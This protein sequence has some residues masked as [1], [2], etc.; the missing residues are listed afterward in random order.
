LVGRDL[1]ESSIFVPYS[2][3]IAKDNKF[4]IGNRIHSFSYYQRCQV[5]L[6]GS[7]ESKHPD[8]VEVI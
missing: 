4:D 8:M 3:D 7:C 1:G 6:T 5:A 2:D